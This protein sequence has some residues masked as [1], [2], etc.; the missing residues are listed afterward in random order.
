[1]RGK[2]SHKIEKTRKKVSF[3]WSGP[4]VFLPNRLVSRAFFTVKLLPDLQVVNYKLFARLEK[5]RFFTKAGK[6]PR[7]WPKPWF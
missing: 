3:F 2:K 7:N 4:P 5:Q 1:L 6:V